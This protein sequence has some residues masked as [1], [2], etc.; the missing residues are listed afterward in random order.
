MRV[1]SLVALALAVVAPRAWGVPSVLVAT[2]ATSAIGVLSGLSTPALDARG[3]A[4]FLGTSTG[5]FRAGSAGV[6]RLV[7][8]GDTLADG[9]VAS[10]VG[11][12]ALASGG[13]AV[14]RIAVRGGGDGVARRC[15]ASFE[16]IAQAGSAVPGSLRLT[17]FR[18]AVAVGPSG[19]AAFTARR[20][21]G[22]W[23]LY[24]AAGGA[25][26]EIVRTGVTAPRGGTFADLRPLA[27]TSAGS[28]GFRATVDNGPDGL[29]EGDGTI[30]RPVVLVNDPS[31]VGGL[32]TALGE[33][34][35]NASDVWAFRARVSLPEGDVTGVF[36]ADASG[37][38]AALAPV[39]LAGEPTPIGGTFQQFANSLVPSVNAGGDVAFRVAVDG[40]QFGSGAFVASAGGGIAAVAAAGQDTVVGALFQLGNPALADDGSVVLPAA[41]RGNAAGL[42][43]IRDGV[44]T[45]LARLGDP[46]DAGTDVRFVGAVVRETA[47]AAALV[48]QREAIFRV[49][50][51]GALTAIAALGRPTPLGGTFARFDPPV[52]GGA[53]GRVVFRADVR[54]G[55]VSEALFEHAGHTV[56]AVT[57]SGRRAPGGGRFLVFSSGGLDVV[58]RPDV[59]GAA[60]VFQGR[61]SGTPAGSGVFLATGRRVRPVARAARPAPGGGRFSTFG[62]PAVRDPR[63]AAFLA[64]VSDGPHA[65]GL[66]GWRE[67]RLRLI[68]AVGAPTGTRLKGTFAQLESPDVSQTGVAFRA[69]VER[70]GAQGIFLAARGRTGAL[71]ASGD[72]APSGG[73]FEAV[74]APAFS[75]AAIVF[76]GDVASGGAG[77]FRVP[78]ERVP[79]PTAAPAVPEALAWVAD[80]TPLG[81]RFLAFGPPAGNRGGA[82]VVEAELEG[83][84]ASAALVR[85]A[86]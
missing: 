7:M 84:S 80:A 78:A 24:L 53:G 40:G 50:D 26:T 81:G 56:R 73:A 42:F 67:G 22:A 69:V 49:T 74:D 75:A 39:A 68:T 11:T 86:P 38:V 28:V 12:P 37:P 70:P 59:A 1:W 48:G 36:R 63:E 20:D 15:G 23:G 64:R 55:R 47:E 32:F 45:P 61:L 85:L 17:A 57:G 62:S 83:A 2:G 54:S 13:C 19:Q 43:V 8:A 76:L 3:R 25:F 77:V 14:M 6:A 41:L 4:I 30:L 65:I 66:F 51:V 82:V 21:D 71:V 29:F 16:W 9:R 34:A 44:V 60:T 46:T 18:P 33:A 52:A 31:P 58:M 5:I 27:V 10:G 35:M 79:V 72:P